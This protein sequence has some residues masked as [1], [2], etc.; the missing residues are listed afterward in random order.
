MWASAT[1]TIR[2]EPF[3]GDAPAAGWRFEVEAK[4]AA[5]GSIDFRGPLVSGRRGDRFLYLNWGTVAPDG[6]FQMFRRAKVGSW[7]QKRRAGSR[8]LGGPG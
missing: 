7:A 4:R 3:P 5:D 2:L 1:V 6:T 8:D